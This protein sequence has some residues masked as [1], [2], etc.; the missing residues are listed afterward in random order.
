[1]GSARLPGKVLQEL[2]GVP[3]LT[4]V[5]RRVKAAQYVNHVC[6]AI[7]DTQ[8]NHP[9]AAIGVSEGVDVYRGSEHDVLARFYW[10]SQRYPECT[11]I[12]RVPADDPFVDKDLIDAAIGL[13]LQELATPGDLG[14][15]AYLQIGGITWPL[16]MGV[17]VM[18]RD[19]LS[20]THMSASSSDD[21]EHVTSWA[22]RHFRQWIVKN[23]YD[24]QHP[25]H[26]RW[27]VDTEEDLAFARGVYDRLYASDPVFGYRAM[28][29][30]GY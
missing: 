25:V 17:E 2:S 3:L 6:L 20:Q 9:L 26:L 18:S 24:S 15:P 7:P 14:P 13:F 29:E 19:A 16:G 12:V 27:T 28:C 4:H 1:M 21:R 11:A 22:R 8:E 30:A 10:A 23:P 5:I